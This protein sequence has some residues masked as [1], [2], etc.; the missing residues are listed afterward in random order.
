MTTE[1]K[2][3]GIPRHTR[4]ML[5]PDDGQTREYGITRGMLVTLLMLGAVFL[6]LL[7]ALMMVF[8][9]RANERQRIGQLE[10]D[11]AAAEVGAQTAQELAAELA[12]MRRMQEQLL[13]ML[14]VDGVDPAAAD[15]I[16]AW[17][18][19]A[20]AS[21]AEGL[22]RAAAVTLSP[23][24][25][26]WPAAGPVTQEYLTG[27]VARGVQPHLGIDIAGNESTPVLAAG[28]GTV[29]RAGHDETLGN[30]VEIQHGLGYLTVYGHCSRLAVGPGA[31]VE[32]G[33][34]IAY[35]GHTGQA[36]ATHLHFEVWQQGEAVDPR[37][38][39]P[40]DPPAR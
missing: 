23:P 5:M 40:G 14:G 24:P 26:R 32:A 37:S 11:L 29:V 18:E 2:S 38:V 7:V 34:V 1:R 6:A 35:M 22:R 13:V 33:Q 4:I 19:H 36:T 31:R 12:D 10:R 21:S 16:A 15:S 17:V 8:A 9:G 3:V 30:F 20:P 28:A 25:D 39:I 27:N